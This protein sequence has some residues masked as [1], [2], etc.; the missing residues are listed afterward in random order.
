M[1]LAKGNG[2]YQQRIFGQVKRGTFESYHKYKNT[3]SS[4]SYGDKM[5][6]IQC[7]GLIR[8]YYDCN[9]KFKSKSPKRLLL[10]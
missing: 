5:A 3:M 2:L 8:L 10:G 4:R 7:K 6:S 1:S 9:I